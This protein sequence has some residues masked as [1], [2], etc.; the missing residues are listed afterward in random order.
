MKAS[1]QPAAIEGKISGSV[2]ARN[3]RRG[4]QPRSIAASSR[5]ESSAPRRDC[6]TTAT[7]HMV[8]VVWAIVTV[9][10]PRS[11]LSATNN[12][13]SDNPVMTSGITSGA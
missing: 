12:N 9:Q 3:A 5:V 11:A 1:I 4:L 8:S 10:K 7:K 2:T 13:S 6:T